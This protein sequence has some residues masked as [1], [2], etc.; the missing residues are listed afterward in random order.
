M[1]DERTAELEEKFSEGL[2]G[3]K[4]VVQGERERNETTLDE[5][6]K[7]LAEGPIYAFEW[8]DEAVKAAVR[9]EY[10]HQVERGL[11]VIEEGRMTADEVIAEIRR[12]IGHR[13]FAQ[14][15]DSTSQGHRTVNIARSEV[16]GEWLTDN[17][18]NKGALL[19]ALDTL[20]V[21]QAAV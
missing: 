19:R 4:L 9:L 1:T 10:I 21:L 16:A 12:S 11:A 18:F 8:S 20:S 13:A 5:F 7:R 2:E 17:H 3:V 15:S 14:L 6:R